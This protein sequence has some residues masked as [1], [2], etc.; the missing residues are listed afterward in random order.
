MMAPDISKVTAQTKTRPNNPAIAA[1]P[2]VS[3]LRMVHERRLR[4]LKGNL[5]M[6]PSCNTPTVP[7]SR[8]DRLAG[9][10]TPSR[11]ITMPFVS[12]QRSGGERDHS[13]FALSI[14]WISHVIQGV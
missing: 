4:L 6:S 14:D 3:G 9:S 8:S 2:I 11:S 10:R 12:E 13:G 1:Q 5:L 7:S